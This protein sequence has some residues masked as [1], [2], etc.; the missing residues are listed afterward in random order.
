MSQTHPIVEQRQPSGD[1]RY[2]A[3]LSFLYDRINYERLVT[4]T[5]R[6]PFRLHRITELLRG[7][8]LA[9]YL[10]Q[11][12]PRPK[13][14][15]VHIAGTKGKGSTA[16][17]VAAA[18]SA[19]GI[20][21][22]LYT[23]PHLTALEERFRVDGQPCRREDVVAL[24]ERIK[25]IAEQVQ[26]AIGPPSF[27]ELTTAISLLHFDA[28][29]CEAVVIEVGLGGRL[30]STNV[31]SPSVSMVTSIG[32]D[33]QHV[34]GND[35]RQI[36]GEKAGIIKQGIPV[37]CGVTEP[38]VAEVVATRAAE[39]DCPYFQIG[40]NFDFQFRESHPWGSQVEYVGHTSPL[41]DRL[42]FS[43]SMEGQH[44]A[45]NAA[46]AVAATDL[47]RDQ[48]V[49]IPPRLVAEGLAGLQCEARIE[50]LVLPHDV[51]VIVD[52][53]HNSD[54]I[55]ALSQCIGHR[56]AGR[57][58]TVVFGTS[59]DKTAEPMLESLAELSPR[60]ILTRFLGNPRYLP[61]QELMA[62]VPASVAEETIVVDDPI[63][64]CRQGLQAAT[65]GGM[66]VVCGS[67][68]LA[69]E[70]RDWLKSQA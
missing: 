48:G 55:K 21:T 26:Q 4:G 38:E 37:I 7:L 12:S 64:A 6:Y 27:F 67:F 49:S 1:A 9:G 44:Q 47:L 69:G 61:P 25:P 31:C 52:A 66:L 65:P 19:A 3:A 70:T 29:G 34:L 56:S 22:G 45:R 2:D 5:S 10:Y 11:D 36:A 28:T 18:L 32:L 8:G 15:L 20:R 62:N 39:H 60:L 63:E 41:R 46:L 24:V 16:A 59:R 53:A 42:P 40:Q 57:P 43:L 51:E 30:D 17:M 68:F 58:I 35:L 50:R 13:V 33:H 14:P 23:S 54:S